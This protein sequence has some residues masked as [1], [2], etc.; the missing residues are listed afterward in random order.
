MA[1]YALS[2]N[3]SKGKKTSASGVLGKGIS[4]F[5][6]IYNPMA[7]GPLQLYVSPTSLYLD[8]K[9]EDLV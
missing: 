6:V 2:L 9:L 1:L 5:I 7:R 4:V 8:S 3:P